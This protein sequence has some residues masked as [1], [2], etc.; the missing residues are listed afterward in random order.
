[1]IGYTVYIHT[2]DDGGEEFSNY[3]NEW[4][5]IDNM[6]NGGKLKLHNKD[7][8][9]IIITSISSWKVRIIEDKTDYLKYISLLSDYIPI[10]GKDKNKNDNIWVDN[11][12]PFIK[13]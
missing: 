1:M 10:S 3:K 11:I 2:F 5:V 6:F 12:M 9:N 8:N 4:E 7:N 13:N